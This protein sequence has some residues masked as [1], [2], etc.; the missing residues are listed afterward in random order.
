MRKPDVRANRSIYLIMA[1]VL[2]TAGCRKKPTTPTAMPL[3]WAARTG[4]VE[5][6][7]TLLAAGAEVDT[8]DQD[9]WTALHWAVQRRHTQ[10]ARLLVSGGAAVNARTARGW[11][12]LLLAM[13]SGDV[14]LIVGT[15]VPR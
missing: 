4:N 8:G 3:H 6:I 2:A 15:S 1:L 11:T 14:D 9:E 12:P 13:P 10:A 5:Q 7:Q